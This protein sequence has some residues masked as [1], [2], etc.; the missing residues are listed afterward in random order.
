MSVNAKAKDQKAALDFMA[1][2]TNKDGQKFRLSGGGNA[3]PCV[4]G[5]DEVVTEGNLPAHGKWFTD[6]A[7]KGYTTP[8]VMVENPETSTNFG[9][10]LQALLLTKPDAKTFATKAANLMNG[11]G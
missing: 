6:V 4:S 5:L 3:V 8:Q 7:K 2:F 11:K 9:T 10:R 1:A